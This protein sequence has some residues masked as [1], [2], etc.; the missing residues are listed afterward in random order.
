MQFL[1]ADHFNQ[2]VKPYL[3]KYRNLSQDLERFLEVFDKRRVIALGGNLYKARFRSSDL[4]KGKSSSFRLI[5]FIIEK[6]QTLVPIAFY[7]KS[8]R[9]DLDKGEINRHFIRILAELKLSQVQL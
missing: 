3:R 5:I 8:D 2:Q 9:A 1:L 4:P 7:F 6:N